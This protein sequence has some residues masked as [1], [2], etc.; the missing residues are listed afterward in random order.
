V[1]CLISCEKAD[2]TLSSRWFGCLLREE[3]IP[4]MLGCKD[5]V[6]TKLFLHLPDCAKEDFSEPISLEVKIHKSRGLYTAAEQT[7]FVIG[8]CEIVWRAS[9]RSPLHSPFQIG[10]LPTTDKK[11]TTLTYQP[12]IMA[13]NACFLLLA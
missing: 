10:F 1:A 12:I 4:Q 7:V 9:R 6:V 13:P 11:L 8:L 2:S 3:E 5:G